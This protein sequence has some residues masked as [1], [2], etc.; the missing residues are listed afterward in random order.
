MLKTN[1]FAILA[2]LVTASTANAQIP[3]P[4][5]PVSG[6]SRQ[7]CIYTESAK[8]NKVIKTYG[9]THSKT[10]HARRAWVKAVKQCSSLPT[11]R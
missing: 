10:A 5:P 2:A 1:L 8:L 4:N 3:I 11:S 6:Q 7:H 9:S